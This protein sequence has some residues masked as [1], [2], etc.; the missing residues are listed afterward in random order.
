MLIA[1]CVTCAPVGCSAWLGD[2]SSEFSAFIEVSPSVVPNTPLPWELGSPRVRRFGD[3]SFQL[4]KLGQVV[5]GGLFVAAQG[6]GNLGTIKLIAGL[7][8]HK[9]LVFW[10]FEVLIFVAG[11]VCARLG[12]LNLGFRVCKV[13]AKR[14][15]QRCLVG[16]LRF[17]LKLAHAKLKRLGVL[18][19]RGENGFEF[20]DLR[21]VGDKPVQLLNDLYD[22]HVQ[23]G[24]GES[25]NDPK[26]SDRGARRGTCMVGGKA[27]VEAGAVTCGAV[28]CSAWLGVAVIWDFGRLV[29]LS[30]DGNTA[31]KT[32]LHQTKR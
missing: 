32:L 12:L 14:Y 3:E 31:D 21:A 30:A 9:N 8:K 11:W 29:K 20:V 22:G 17:R 18:A 4:P 26:L 10:V 23:I 13:F 6:C 5:E 1:A 15:Y 2:G 27:A 19:Q 28:R 25:P 24:I 16:L 7:E